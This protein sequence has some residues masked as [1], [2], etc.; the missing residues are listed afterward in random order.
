MESSETPG[1]TKMEVSMSVFDEIINDENFKCCSILFLNKIDLFREKIL[2]E[3][4]LSEFEDKFPTF[5]DYMA[6]NLNTEL[7]KSDIRVEN[8]EDKLFWGAVKFIEAKFQDLIQDKDAKNLVIY[9]TCAIRT[10]QI[11]VVFS[12]MKDYIFVERMKNSGVRF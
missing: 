5:K 1:K 10:D 12:A 11:E 4:G 6:N 2:T 9:P 3:K 8:D 7:E